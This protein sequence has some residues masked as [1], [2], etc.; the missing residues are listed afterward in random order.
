M[1]SFLEV[2]RLVRCETVH[3]Y[4]PC[5]DVIPQT[6]RIQQFVS[7][8]RLHLSVELSSDLKCMGVPGVILRPFDETIRRLTRLRECTLALPTRT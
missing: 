5:D 8:R 3:A 4:G 1:I 2:E 7:I 6:E